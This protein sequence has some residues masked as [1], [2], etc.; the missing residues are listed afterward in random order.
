[1]ADASAAARFVHALAAAVLREG[2]GAAHAAEARAA[3]DEVFAGQ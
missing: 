3:L 1:M 2:D